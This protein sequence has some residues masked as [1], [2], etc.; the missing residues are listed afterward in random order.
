MIPFKSYFEWHSIGVSHV[1]GEKAPFAV[2]PDDFKRP[3][4]ALALPVVRTII[5]HLTG[6]P[7]GMQSR[8]GQDVHS[9]TLEGVVYGDQH[10]IQYL[11]R[12]KDV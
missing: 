6:S 10:R 5:I 11:S 1:H 3:F 9:I 2:L 8:E 4:P 7:C 12:V